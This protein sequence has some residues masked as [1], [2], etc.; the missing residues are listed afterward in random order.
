VNT[1]LLKQIAKYIFLFV[2]SLGLLWFVLRQV[3]LKDVVSRLSEVNYYWI[4]ASVS[5][6]I[7]SHGVRAWRWNLMLQPL[8][9]RPS[10]GT[11]FTAIMVGYL[12]N[13]A[14]PRFGEVARC[15]VLRKN[16]GIPFTAAFGTVLAERA[17]DLIMLLLI[18]GVTLLLEFDRL[19]DFLGEVFAQGSGPSTG[20]LLWIG[21][22]GISLFLGGLYLWR[23][24][25][26]RLMIYPFYIKV[27][28][29]GRDL[30][31]GLLSI[32]RIRQ[33]G[34]FWISTLL[35]WALYYGMS[36]VVVFSI[37]QTSDISLV[38]GLSI[39]AMGGI[40]MAAPVQGG[41]GA[42]HLLV[43]GT[44]IVYGAT[45]SDAVLLTLL[46]HTS[47]ILLIL[48]AGGISLLVSMFAP[49]KALNHE[50][51]PA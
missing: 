35:I 4:L 27:I 37:P 10:F 3:D 15:G 8:G 16:A 9:Y 46:L 29:L 43:T 39:L 31:A 14:L 18:V 5:F 41:I 21:V 51:T 30:V 6:G 44:L 2:V 45:Q 25:H 20:L 17:L 36:Y 49:T 12:A 47:Q 28:R 40:G 23:L 42:Y 26:P 7:L 32:G 22:A 1:P 48:L 11:T 34:A 50:T 33:Q 24:F 38:A 13:L 19:G